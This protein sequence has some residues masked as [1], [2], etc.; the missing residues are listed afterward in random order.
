MARFSAIDMKTINDELITLLRNSN[1]AVESINT[2]EINQELVG[3]TQ[4]IN[5]TLKDADIPGLVAQSRATL[6]E[7]QNLA[8]TLNS[9][10]D[11]AMNDYH[12]LADRLDTTLVS[13]ENAANGLSSTVQPQSALYYE[14]NE[15]MREVR[16]AA[17]ELRELADYLERNPRSLLTGRDK[18]E[19]R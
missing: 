9:Q 13:V 19:E 1:A 7:V 15:T 10:V 3:T 18:P 5:A 14:L 12:R 17:R 8:Q 6:Q 16:T 2:A 11:P 4:S